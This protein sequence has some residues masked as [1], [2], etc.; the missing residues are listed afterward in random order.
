MLIF[1]VGFMGSGK[2]FTG[3]QLSV[4]FD[5]PFIDMDY[6]IEEEEGKTISAIFEEK[7]EPYFRQ[8]ERDFIMDLEM[9]E[10]AVIATGGGVPCF[11][12]NMNVLNTIGVTIF[13]DV[14]KEIIVS[15]LLKGL[16]T[17]P[18]LTGMN[19]YDLEFYYD[20][21]MKERRP[22]YEKANFSLKHQ[23]IEV[24]SDLLRAFLS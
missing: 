18:L 3:K 1:L 22:F 19:Q 12:E 9:E 10:T 24:I 13:L 14:D 4:T 21:K 16:D 5:I 20:R 23:D 17:R 6:A 2:S 8:L 7:G 11:N 15:R